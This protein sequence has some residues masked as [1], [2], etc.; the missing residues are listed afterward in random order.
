[1]EE[2]KSLKDMNTNVIFTGFTKQCY[3][4]SL[5][6]DFRSKRGKIWET[7]ENLAYIITFLSPLP[8][9]PSFH[10]T[11]VMHHDLKKRCNQ[12]VWNKIL[13]IKPCIGQISEKKSPTSPGLV[14]PV[15]SYLSKIILKS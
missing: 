14:S 15:F 6:V 10:R 1:L 11:N 7:S 4:T 8:H 3:M 2:K 12:Q 5:S 13:N 9:P